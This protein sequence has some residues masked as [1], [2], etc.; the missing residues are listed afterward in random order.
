[1][2]SPMKGGGGYKEFKTFLDDGGRGIPT[3]LIS[4]FHLFFF[5]R[6]LWA[7]IPM[8]AKQEVDRLSGYLR[9]SHVGCPFHKKYFSVPL[10]PGL[11]LPAACVQL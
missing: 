8:R 6:L 9:G 7:Y 4:L 2:M 1:M 5:L 10:P 3:S 11:A